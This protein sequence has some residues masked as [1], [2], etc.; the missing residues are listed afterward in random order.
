[1]WKREKQQPKWQVIWIGQHADISA[2]PVYDGDFDEA[3]KS[4][5]ARACIMPGS[6]D[7]F[8]TADD[9][10]YE[11][12]LMPNAVFNPIESI[13]GHFAARRINSEDNKCIDDNLK[14]LLALSTNG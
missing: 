5:K 3:L 7:L 12:K 8:C 1:L 13:W 2:N 10:E 14:R 4:I 11:S 6:T 9:N